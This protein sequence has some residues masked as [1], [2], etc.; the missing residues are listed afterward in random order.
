MASSSTGTKRK[1]EGGAEV[2]SS[3]AKVAKLG[4]SGVATKHEASSSGARSS[5]E[6]ADRQQVKHELTHK[7]R[8]PQKKAKVEKANT[9]DTVK[10]EKANTDDTEM[11]E[12]ANTDDTETPDPSCSWD[13]YF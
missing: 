3:N 8:P 1:H 9:D 6:R 11:V 13:P 4:L 2:A 5:W 10:V 12:K 7:A